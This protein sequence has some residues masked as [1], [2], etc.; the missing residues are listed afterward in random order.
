MYERNGQFQNWST[1]SKG[2]YP[3]ETMVPFRTQIITVLVHAKYLY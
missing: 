3:K 1:T 2:R